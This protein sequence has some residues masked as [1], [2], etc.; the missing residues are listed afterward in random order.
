MVDIVLLRP[1]EVAAILHVTTSTLSIWRCTKRY[2]LPY[3]K[4]G[5]SVLYK[6]TDVH[7]F[8]ESRSGLAHGEEEKPAAYEPKYRT[9]P[10]STPA[11]QPRGRNIRGRGSR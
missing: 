4:I 9:T 5:K 8:I 11:P 2:P 10:R 7:A 3:T 1:K 6:A